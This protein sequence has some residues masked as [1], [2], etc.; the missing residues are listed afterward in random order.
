MIG[1]LF[2]L[3][4]SPALKVV[5]YALLLF[6]D[7]MHTI[8]PRWKMSRCGLVYTAIK[9]FDKIIKRLSPFDVGDEIARRC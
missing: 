1:C 9:S 7:V 3:V 5:V 2:A 6:R 8:Y 4:G